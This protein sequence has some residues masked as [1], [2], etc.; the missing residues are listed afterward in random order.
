MQDAILAAIVAVL[1]LPLIFNRR[2]AF[3][4]VPALGALFT[5]GFIGPFVNVI[6]HLALAAIALGVVAALPV[7]LGRRSR[8]GGT[9]LIAG[10]SFAML[11]WLAI[12]YG[13]YLAREIGWHGLTRLGQRSEWPHGNIGLIWLPFILLSPLLLIAAMLYEAICAWVYSRLA[14]SD[15]KVTPIT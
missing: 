14:R 1:A 5:L 9:A 6:G 12:G 13:I 7:A 3:V 10:M 11:L 2:E 15:T 4:V 8:S